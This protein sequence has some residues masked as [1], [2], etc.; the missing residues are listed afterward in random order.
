MPQHVITNELSMSRDRFKFLWR[1]FHVS[2]DFDSKDGEEV[3]ENDNEELVE[4]TVERVVY[5]Q[6]EMLD[7]DQN[8]EED[9]K[10]TYQ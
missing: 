4:Q 1:H 6:E 9:E 7:E 10:I 3:E 8:V 5:D 2:S